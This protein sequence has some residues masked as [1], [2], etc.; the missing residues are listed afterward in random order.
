[1]DLI[2]QAILPIGEITGLAILAG[3]AYELELKSVKEQFFQMWPFQS[4]RT[5]GA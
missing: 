2:T 3:C 5:L 1:M 4:F